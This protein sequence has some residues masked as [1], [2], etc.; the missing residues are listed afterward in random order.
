MNFS[1]CGSGSAFNLAF[2]T[3]RHKFKKT[4]APLYFRKNSAAMGSSW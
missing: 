2:L 4:N 1:N 3:D